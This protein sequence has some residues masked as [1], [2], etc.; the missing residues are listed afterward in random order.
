M[1]FSYCVDSENRNIGRPPNNARRDNPNQPQPPQ[2]DQH[3]MYPATTAYQYTLADVP[4]LAEQAASM[5]AQN[6]TDKASY[7]QYYTDFYTKQV[8]QVRLKR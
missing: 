2:N 4:K 1:T 5:Y 7:L 3:S 6:P 8:S